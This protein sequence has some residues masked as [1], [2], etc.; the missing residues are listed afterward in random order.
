MLMSFYAEI[1]LASVRLE[2]AKEDASEIELGD[3]HELH[4][5]CTP[6]VLITSGLELEEQQ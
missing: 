1:T 4:E 5:N 2:L 3:F 6:S